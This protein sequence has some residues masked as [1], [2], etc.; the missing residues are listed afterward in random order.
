MARRI[1][2]VNG[3]HANGD[4]PPPSTIAAQ[5]VHNQTRAPVTQQNGETETFSQLLHEI[6]HNHAAT[7]ETNVDVNVKLV[8]VVAEAGLAPL[9]DGNPF[10]QWDVLIPQAVD[11]IAVIGAT[12]KRQPDVLFTPTSQDGPQLFLPLLARLAAICGRQKCEE[13]P[14]VP[15]LDAMFH[16]LET[17]IDLWQDAQT[18]QQ[19]LQECVDGT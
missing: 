11:S 15:L 5:I 14:I 4:A 3:V 8:S 6:L 16:V 12:I 9:A 1:P 13:L 7:P 19:V 2:N 18:L 10:P 17:S